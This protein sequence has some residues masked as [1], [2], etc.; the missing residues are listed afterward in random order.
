MLVNNGYFF[1][2][3]NNLDVKQLTQ[4]INQAHSLGLNY[5][6][7]EETLSPLV[8]GLDEVK[9]RLNFIKDLISKTHYQNYKFIIYLRSQD[10]LLESWYTELIQQGGEQ[11]FN[12]FLRKQ[13]TNDAFDYHKLI[14]LLEN[15]FENKELIVRVFN[16]QLLVD[17]CP[18]KDFLSIFKL[19]DLN[20]NPMKVNQSYSKQALE[21]AWQVP[22]KLD[23]SC[24]KV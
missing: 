1:R 14:S 3:M 11:S 19:N 7:S 15:Q 13:N 8:E 22:L 16:K 21:V 12:D 24:I 2:W 6:L 23:S 9:N 4:E 18:I 20:I 5:I 10:E 17:E